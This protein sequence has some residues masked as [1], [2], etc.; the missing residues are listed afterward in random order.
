[1][2][3]VGSIILSIYCAVNIIPALFIIVSITFLGKNH[4]LLEMRISQDEITTLSP[5]VLA[6]I[7]SMAIFANGGVIALCLLSLIAI[8]VGLKRRIKWVFWALLTAMSFYV[9]A[10]LVADI[11][12]QSH[13]YTARIASVLIPALGFALVAIGLFK[14]EQ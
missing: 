6:L 12:S 4:P 1:M 14:S 9:L 11:V 3:R 10:G 7:N 13:Y 5:E 8:W 2:L